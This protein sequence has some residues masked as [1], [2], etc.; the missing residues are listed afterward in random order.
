MKMQSL[1]RQKGAEV[2]E[3]AI[4]SALLFLI[5][6]GIIEFSVALF[7]KATLTNAGREGAR[8]GILF[9][10]APRDIVAEDAAINQAIDDYAASYLISLGGPAA[11][12]TNI[13]RTDLSANG[14]FDAGDQITVTITYPYQ[15]LILPKFLGTLGGALNLSSTIVMRAE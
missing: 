2:V 11:M 4:T 14:V 10:P 5:L 12:T 7:D 15:F 9:R 3:F 8:T 13:Q 1:H 6:F